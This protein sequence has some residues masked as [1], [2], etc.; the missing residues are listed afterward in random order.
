MAAATTTVYDNAQKHLDDDVDWASDTIK[1]TLHSSSYT[2]ATTHEFFSSV[3]NELA[4]ANGY[5]AG[6]ATLGT[7]SRTVTG[8]VTAY[9][10]AATT[11]TPGA[12]QT[13]TARYAVVRKDTGTASTSPVLCYVLLDSAP[14]DVS[15]TNAAFTLTW[16]STDGVF[17]VT[18]S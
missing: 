5:T 16:D 4:T 8:H 13:L 10:A 17:K 18:A 2:P 15:A 3:T 11:W 9:K 6:G 1:V 12:G 7:K 14:A